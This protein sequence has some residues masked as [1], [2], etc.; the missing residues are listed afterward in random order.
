MA[1]NLR[2]ARIPDNKGNQPVDEPVFSQEE[3]A[4][5]STLPIK[6]MVQAIRQEGIPAQVSNTAGTY[7]CNDLMYGLL[8]HIHHSFPT[9]RGGFVHVP[10]ATCQV[11]DKPG[12]PSLSV[13]EMIKG[14]TAALGACVENTQDVHTAEGAEH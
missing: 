5:F 13:P 4:Y 7:V 10:Y 8:Y 11:V 9:I 3:N 12:T 6:A 1:I 2:D 14:I